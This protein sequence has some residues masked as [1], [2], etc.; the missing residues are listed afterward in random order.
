MLG[1]PQH[2]SPPRAFSDAFFVVEREKLIEKIHK[3]GERF[4]PAREFEKLQEKHAK[5]FGTSMPSNLI[6]DFEHVVR[7]GVG[8]TPIAAGFLQNADGKKI[9]KMD[10]LPEVFMANKKLKLLERMRNGDRIDVAE[11]LSKVAEKFEQNYGVALPIEVEDEFSHP[12]AQVQSMDAQQRVPVPM[13]AR[14]LTAQA[15]AVPK[16]L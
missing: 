1:R 15:R 6:A 12:A 9:S 13:P 2:P 14:I 10:F 3:D 7:D 11:E 4:D 8:L 5:V 16:S